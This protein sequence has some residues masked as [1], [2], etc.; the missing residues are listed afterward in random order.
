MMLMK[1]ND[2]GDHN[3]WWRMIMVGVG[4]GDGNSECND[5]NGVDNWL[6]WWCC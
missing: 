1:N 4:N 5:G 6:W 2:D 3:E